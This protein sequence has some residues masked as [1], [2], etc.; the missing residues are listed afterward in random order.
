M[1][2][3]QDHHH[4]R[5]HGRPRPRQAQQPALPD[6]GR[7]RSPQTRRGV[8]R[9]AGAAIVHL[10]VRTR[11]RHAH[12][13]PERLHGRP[14]TSIRS[15]YGH[16]HRDHHGRRR[17]HDAGGAP[18]ARRPSIPRWPAWTAAPSTSAT[19]TS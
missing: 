19:T 15:K 7:R 6:H 11:R 8:P 13:G 17:G 9:S 12:P 1:M 5:R 3:R 2:D 4:L 16:R 10:H 14:S 18:P